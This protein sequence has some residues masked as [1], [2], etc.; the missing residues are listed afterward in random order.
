MSELPEGW[1]ATSLAEACY[2]QYGKNLP[3]AKLTK[4]GYPVFGANGQIGFYSTYHYEEPRVLITC[5]GATC[6]TINRSLAKSFVTNNSIIIEPISP[7]LLDRRFLEYQLR[8]I[9]K[10][11]VITGSAQPQI[12]LKN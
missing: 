1:T 10:A 11:S 7:K 12:T 4:E 2:S 9:D 3:T 8:S 5:R 6:G